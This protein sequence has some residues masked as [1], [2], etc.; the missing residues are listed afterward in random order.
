MN[1]ATDKLN[2]IPPPLK[3]VLIVTLD[4]FLLM[5]CLWIAYVIRL[6]EVFI[7]NKTQVL[8]ALTAPLVAV[9]I[10]AISGLY[11]A[12]IRYLEEQA[13]WVAAKA[14]TLATLTWAVLIEFT[15][16]L[17][18]ISGVAHTTLFVYWA[19]AMV[20]IVGGRLMVRELF[21]R[22][23]RNRYKGN[24]VLVYGAG[25][26]GVQL[27]QALW[28]THDLYPVA[29]LDD[30]ARMLNREV[31]GLKVHSINNLNR[32]IENYGIKE[33]LLAI[34]N[35]SRSR[36]REVIQLLQRYPVHARV[37]PS[38][39]EIARGKVS[40]SDLREVEVEDLLGRNSVPPNQEL[41]TQNITGK[42]VMITGAGGSI[43]SELCRQIVR[44]NPEQVILFDNSEHALY[45]I[46]RRLKERE[47]INPVR[48]VPILGSVLT[49]SLIE[50]ILNKYQVD[51]IYHAAAYKHV[52]LVETNELEGVNN[53]VF[54]TLT[55]AEAAI[56]CGVQTF[57]LVSSDKAVRPT[58]IMGASKRLS[59]LVLQ[60]LHG[61]L[62]HTR[63]TEQNT[64]PTVFSMVRFGN[65]LDSSGSVIPLF[66]EQI[67]AGG[68][69]TV[70]HAQ[71]TRYFMSIPEAA[72]LVLQAG[73]MAKGGD[74][75][76]LDMGEPVRILD[77]A[78]QMIELSGLTVLS[79][80]NPDGD[81]LIELTGLR[82]GEKLR[83]ELLIGK[84]PIGTEHPKILRAKEKMLPWPKLRVLLD[85]IKVA[86]ESVDVENARRLVMHSA[87]GKVV[88]SAVAVTQ[89]PIR[90]PAAVEQISQDSPG[91]IH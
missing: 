82:P 89:A 14:V 67:R 39:S 88:S 84:N 12:V 38:V 74:V 69:V 15:G 40:I 49:R 45:Q 30:D 19:L 6:N 43:G 20:T 57:I 91:A 55:I 86:Y 76:V 17:G 31:L 83:E 21:W 63:A 68:P 48:I 33:V 44:L 8:M 52:P 79:E 75:F 60:A 26:A 61:R 18:G 16:L 73:A 81:I 7:P 11:R 22:P 62:Q 59:E 85:E 64:P 87:D 51:T 80:Q 46:D 2:L 3:R 56:K 29:F 42:T 36:R 71:V 37:L 50:H 58:N 5:G 47:W 1:K 25:E 34:P 53:N 10:F 27:V 70:T 90:Q 54:G 13:L 72:Q 35:A 23:V 24:N 9:P 66:R 78:K 77:L 28:H 32:L 4:V 41:L 65:V